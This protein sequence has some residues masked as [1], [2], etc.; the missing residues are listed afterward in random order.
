MLKFVKHCLFFFLFYKALVEK[1]Q[2][3]CSSYD[4][5]KNEDCSLIRLSRCDNIQ[6]EVGKLKVSSNHQLFIFII[7]SELFCL[8]SFLNKAH[9]LLQKYLKYIKKLSAMQLSIKSPLD[10]LVHNLS[11][12]IG[13]LAWWYP[14]LAI[15]ISCSH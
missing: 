2:E 3:F 13:T 4:G 7:E 8:N 14:I 10:V 15:V 9:V 12:L 5:I 6:S 11:I 1:V